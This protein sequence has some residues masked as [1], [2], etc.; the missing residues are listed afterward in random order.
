MGNMDSSKMKTP[1]S[2][3]EEDALAA[4]DDALRWLLR[5]RDA[6]GGVFPERIFNAL[7][8]LRPSCSSEVIV[9]KIVDDEV[10]FW[11]TLRAVDDADPFNGMWHYTG[12][13]D[14]C[15]D[16]LIGGVRRVL[17]RELGG[18]TLQTCRRVASIYP[19]RS[20][21]SDILSVLFMCTLGEEP[22]SPEQGRWFSS[23]EAMSLTPLR[24]DGTGIIPSHLV[25][26]SLCLRA[27]GRPYDCGRIEPSPIGMRV[28][29]DDG[30]LQDV[31]LADE[32]DAGIV[33]A[34]VA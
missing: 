16:Y 23:A 30:F 10:F 32:I 29:G 13:V 34:F 14:R 5:Y 27:L 11:L 19:V 21:R 3:D 2:G 22:S 17:D 6:H 20:R 31:V 9:H 1:L 18:R 24:K 25:G 15:G 33:R 7:I 26:L 12:T 8:R 28:K 4:C